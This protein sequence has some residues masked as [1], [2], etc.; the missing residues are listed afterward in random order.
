MLK[1]L[2]L[3]LESL[4]HGPLLRKIIAALLWAAAGIL[5]FA[6]LFYCIDLI[7]CLSGTSSA[8]QVLGAIIAILIILGGVALMLFIL[9]TRIPDVQAHPAGQSYSITHTAA[10]LL[11]LS[12]EI[13]AVFHLIT[14]LS[15]GIMFWFGSNP[16]LPYF[17]SL[18]WRI[19][20]FASFPSFI[21]GLLSILACVFQAAVTLVIYYLMAELLLMFRDIA[22][23]NRR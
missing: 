19:M 12:G 15:A 9:Y 8:A 18:M 20:N 14:G 6:G 22:L 21:S 2:K 5:V 16:R 4:P 13:L 3:L 1:K 17:D 11:R 23:R 7:L 10:L